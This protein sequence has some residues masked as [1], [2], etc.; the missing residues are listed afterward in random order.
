MS[1]ATEVVDSPIW[2]TS[3]EVETIDKIERVVDGLPAV[4]AYSLGQVLRYFDRAGKKDA[5]ETD[6][7]KAN[8]YAHR[9]VYGKWRGSDE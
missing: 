4:Q 3:G 8:N 2:Y 7:G 6:L 5:T 9:L 1:D